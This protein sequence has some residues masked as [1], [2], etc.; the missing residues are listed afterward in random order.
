MKVLKPKTLAVT[1]FLAG[2]YYSYDDYDVWASFI[3]YAVGDKVHDYASKSQYQCLV[4]NTGQNPATVG[5]THW[6]RIGTAQFWRPFDGNLTSATYGVTYPGSSSGGVLW[7]SPVSSDVGFSTWVLEG[8]GTF[9]TV[10]V[11]VT[12]A[13]SVRVRFY[14]SAGTTT[15]DETI[16]AVDPSNVI[17]AYSYFFAEINTRRDF[18]FDDIDGWGSSNLSQLYITISN[19]GFDV[20]ISLGEI[21][22]GEAHEL[23]ACHA[24]AQIQLIDYSKKEIDAYGTVTI[25]QRAYSLNGSFEVEVLAADRPRVQNLMTSLRAT[26]CVYF[27]SAGDAN[28]GIVIYGY[29]K[30]YNTTYQTPERAFASLEVEGMI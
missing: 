9:S 27:P 6:V 11:L 16:Y 25:V 8:L 19:E 15:Y 28:A 23:G 14:N 24:D 21:V 7:S 2:L 17:D 22:I 29:V 26:P 5:S 12:D 13:A 18:I 1:D 20:P 3:A 30:D 10:A 4:A